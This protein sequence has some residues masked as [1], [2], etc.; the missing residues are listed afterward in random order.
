MKQKIQ[1]VIY[2]FNMK[3]LRVYFLFVSNLRKS[4]YQ[5]VT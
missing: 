5:K 3:N 1:T 2:I 4:T